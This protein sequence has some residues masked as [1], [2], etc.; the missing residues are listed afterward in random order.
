MV[1]RFNNALALMAWLN[2]WIL[3][4]V[5]VSMVTPEDLQRAGAQ[6]D[7]YPTLA[8]ACVGAFITFVSLC[9]FISLLSLLWRR[10]PHHF[11]APRTR[12]VIQI[13]RLPAALMH[14]FRVIAFRW[15]ISLGDSYTLNFAEV[16]MTAGYIAILFAWS[17]ANCSFH[18]VLTIW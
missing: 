12:D 13:R 7:L 15:T 4:A 16:F 8:W 1:S 14:T 10:V 2:V 6:A 9:H 3:P 17:F 18:L 11:S 5:A